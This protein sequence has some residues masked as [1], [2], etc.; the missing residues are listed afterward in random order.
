MGEGGDFRAFVME[1]SSRNVW[2]ASILTAIM[3]LL[4]AFKA[5][6]STGLTPVSVLMAAMPM[7][8]HGGAAVTMKYRPEL[9]EGCLLCTM[10]FRI[11]FGFAM[12]E[13]ILPIAP[14]VELVCNLHLDKLVEIIMMGLLEPVR[15]SFLVPLR[16]LLAMAHG[17]VYEQMGMPFPWLQ[18][19]L[20]HA[21]GLLVGVLLDRHYRSLYRAYKARHRH[22]SKAALTEVPCLEASATGK[23]SLNAAALMKPCINTAAAEKSSFSAAAVVKPSLDAAALAGAPSVAAA[24]AAATSATGSSSAASAASAA[25]ACGRVGADLPWNP[26]GVAAVLVD[27]LPEQK[28]P[29]VAMKKYIPYKSLLQDKKRVSILLQG[30]ISPEALPKDAG[31]LLARKVEERL[32]SGY[33]A[34]MAIRPGCVVVCFDVCK[35]AREGQQQMD[36]QEVCTLTAEAVQAWRQEMGEELLDWE[37]DEPLISVQGPSSLEALRYSMVAHSTVLVLPSSAPSPVPASAVEQQQMPQQQPPS[38]QQPQP[39][40]GLLHA[41]SVPTINVSLVVE[42]TAPANLGVVRGWRGPVDNPE[43]LEDKES[44]LCLLAA[45]QGRF[46]PL[47]ILHIEGR[48]VELRI[49]LPADVA[50]ATTSCTTAQLELWARGKLACSLQVLLV[51][52]SRALVAAELEAWKL[53]MAASEAAGFVNDLVLWIDFHQSNREPGTRA[54]CDACKLQQLKELGMGLLNHSLCCDLVGIAGLL[55]EGLTQPPFHLTFEALASEA[56]AYKPEFESSQQEPDQ[57]GSNADSAHINAQDL[58]A[59][60]KHSGSAAV[61]AQCQAWEAQ[62]ANSTPIP[63]GR[64]PSRPAALTLWQWVVAMALPFWRFACWACPKMGAAASS[65]LA[66]KSKSSCSNDKGAEARADLAAK[67]Q[68]YRAWVTAQ[69]AMLTRAYLVFALAHLSILLLR[70]VQGDHLETDA[71]A[72]AILITF[73]FFAALGAHK[74]PRHSEV[75][76]VLAY[77]GRL[78]SLLAQGSG[79]IPIPSSFFTALFRFRTEVILEIFFSSSMELVR[80]SW[81]IPLRIALG[82]GY[83]SLYK[84]SGFAHPFLESLAMNLGSVLVS[85]MVELR[86]RRIFARHKA[87]AASAAATSVAAAT[88]ASPGK[89][90]SDGKDFQHQTQE[91]DKRPLGADL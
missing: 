39:Q 68:E 12:M 26:Q 9:Q 42:V 59:A 11:L 76:A 1:Q 38:P 56:F 64:P 74:L 67:A 60:A 18:G 27:T 63:S 22:K 20:I 31:V 69:T 89:R 61:L 79:L 15:P 50:A 24:A 32:G 88:A 7:C 58:V 4:S 75:F 77:L 43:E 41:P 49:A 36:L 66:T 14:W 51:P 40:Y 2:Y 82:G 10:L 65:A 8:T 87:A 84:K 55:L 54:S 45:V 25:C 90:A 6:K 71:P 73:Y 3:L 70:S 30:D 80:L 19:S 37:H 48:R 91:L 86:H 17:G 72:L 78:T 44:S 62:Q 29:R 16:I 57:A 83:M 46:L 28:A 13:G 21:A 35:V 23:S 85:M 47:D 34:G 53:A 52:A 33:V 81:L 5:V